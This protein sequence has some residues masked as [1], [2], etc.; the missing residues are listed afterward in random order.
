MIIKENNYHRLKNIENE[1]IFLLSKDIDKCLREDI[2]SLK[3]FINEVLE[4]I[5]ENKSSNE[6]LDEV[7]KFLYG[8]DSNEIIIKE[9]KRLEEL[10]KQIKDGE[11]Q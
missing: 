6:N 1:A 2:E 4:N 5:R 11:E 9:N 7:L 8:Y 10:K 3:N